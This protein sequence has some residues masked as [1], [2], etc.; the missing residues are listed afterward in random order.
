MTVSTN[1]RPSLRLFG[2]GI[3]LLSRYMPRFFMAILLHGT[4][5]AASPYIVIVLMAEWLERLATG[6]EGTALWIHGGITVVTAMALM[7]AEGLLRRWKESKWECLYRTCDRM[8]MDRCISMDHATLADADVRTSL[9]KVRENTLALGKGLVQIPEVFQNL[10]TGAVGVLCALAAS[11]HLMLSVPFSAQATSVGRL[12]AMLLWIGLAVVLLLSEGAARASRHSRRRVTDR[13]VELDRLYYTMMDRMFEPSGAAYI[14]LYRQDRTVERYLKEIDK[15]FFSRDGIKRY[16]TSMRQAVWSSGTT[17]LWF[18]FVCTAA[19]M[20]ARQGGCGVA[21][22]VQAI[23]ALTWLMQHAHQCC[24]GAVSLR[25]SLPFLQTVFVFLDTH[26]RMYHGSLTTEKRTDGAYT[27]EFRHVTFC[28]PGQA[29]PALCDVSVTLSAGTSVAVVGENGSGKST[30]LKLLCRLYDPDEGEI[31]LNGI[32][33]RKYNYEEYMA[34]VSAVFQDGQLV[35]QPLFNNIAADA[36]YDEAAVDRCLRAVGAAQSPYPD[37]QPQAQKLLVA[38]ALYKQA[39]LLLLDEATSYADPSAQAALYEQLDRLTE[40][41]T[42][43]HISHHPA[44]WR[45]C[46]RILVLDKGRLVEC[47]TH[48]ELVALPGGVYRALWEA[49]TQ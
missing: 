33:I 29:K 45:R 10:F 27:W 7:M 9:H 32:D 24:Q 40:N 47:G 37:G 17:A 15:A 20:V 16:T 22:T 43:V 19:V 11:W 48:K 18:G 34:L 8:V 6:G 30:F 28:Y 2:R 5:K 23:G 3:R 42:V 44:V 21:Q 36:V 38:R 1:E 4:V 49:G 41:R 26:P 39:P 25:D 35:A 12:W 14:R 46:R 31:L 13:V